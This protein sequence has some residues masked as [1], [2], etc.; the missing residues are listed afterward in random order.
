M[1]KKARQEQTDEVRDF[2]KAER[3][4]RAAGIGFT[5]VEGPTPRPAEPPLAA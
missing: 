4:L 1:K 2:A 3:T 5:V